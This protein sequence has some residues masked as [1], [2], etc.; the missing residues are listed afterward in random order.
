MNQKF[1][2]WKR[3]ALLCAGLAVI[4]LL[5]ALTPYPAYALKVAVHLIQ[6][7]NGDATFL[8][9]GEEHCPVLRLRTAVDSPLPVESVWM[10]EDGKL[11]CVETTELTRGTGYTAECLFVQ[12]ECGNHYAVHTYGNGSN[13]GAPNAY[14]S[15]EEWVLYSVVDG[16][17]TECYRFYQYQELDV[18][19]EQWDAFFTG[20]A[21]LN[22][23][24]WGYNEAPVYFDQPSL[25][26]I[27]SKYSVNGKPLRVIT[28]AQYA[29]VLDALNL[30]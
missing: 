8:H 13:Y 16:T 14:G 25:H 2:Q 23:C 20:D 24:E 18:P 6:E 3:P 30:N 7:P 19:Q 27:L 29:A 11:A 4:L 1:T 22:G 9:L 28:A 10:Y 17:W 5:C 12:T 15:W 26:F 21:Y